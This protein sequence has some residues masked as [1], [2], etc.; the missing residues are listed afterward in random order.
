MIGYKHSDYAA[1]LREFGFEKFHIKNAAQT[2]SPADGPAR[3][4]PVLP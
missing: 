1:S 4:V 3:S 2:L